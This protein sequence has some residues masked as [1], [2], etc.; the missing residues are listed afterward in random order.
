MLTHP[1]PLTAEAPSIYLLVI[2]LP[3]ARPLY[4]MITRLLQ[5]KG[6]A[7]AKMTWERWRPNNCFDIVMAASRSRRRRGRELRERD[8]DEA[9][10]GQTGPNDPSRRLPRTCLSRCDI[11]Q[12]KTIN[13]EGKEKKKK[14]KSS[15]SSMRSWQPAVRVAGLFIF[16]FFP[17]FF[18]SSQNLSVFLIRRLAFLFLPTLYRLVCHS[19]FG[20]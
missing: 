8:S 6:G 10:P 11:K 2:G 9:G 1:C 5:R 7:A 4:C 15:I 13:T 20:M 19:M 17:P 14:K 3:R 16:A 12:E 18:F